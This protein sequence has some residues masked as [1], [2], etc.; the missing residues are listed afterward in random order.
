MS[1]VNVSTTA[2]ATLESTLLTSPN[3]FA[4]RKL[5]LTV[6]ASDLIKENQDLLLRALTAEKKL[7]TLTQDFEKRLIAEHVKGN[8]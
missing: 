3:P 1:N 8:P 4:D 7:A 6:F 5:K 2:A